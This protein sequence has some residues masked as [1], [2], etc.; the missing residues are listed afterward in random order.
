MSAVFSQLFSIFLSRGGMPPGPP[1]SLTDAKRSVTQGVLRRDQL[2]WC[3]GMQDWKPLEEVIDYVEKKTAS[4][5]PAIGAQTTTA[6]EQSVERAELPGIGRAGVWRKPSNAVQSDKPEVRLEKP[7]FLSG[8]SEPAKSEP[9]ETAVGPAS[10][11]SLRSLIAATRSW[12]ARRT[13]PGQ[14]TAEEMGAHLWSFAKQLTREFRASVEER[15]KE[16][17]IPINEVVDF[18][19]SQEI[20]VFHIWLTAKIIDQHPAAI[21]ALNLRYVRRQSEI[22]ESYEH[23]AQRVEYIRAVK[24]GFAVRMQTYQ[25]AWNFRASRAQTI[26]AACLLKNILG[27]GTFC[28]KPVENLLV[29]HINSYLYRLPRTIAA[30]AEQ[31]EVVD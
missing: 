8:A 29:T 20:L 9:D 6:P 4:L 5:L 16:T 17:G 7:A 26:A 19:L 30:Y 2:A 10:S 24:E 11:L 18:N 21:E 25:N 28:T 22:A 12:P 13:K 14:V 23:H 1:I 27:P 3:R 15:F 31:Y